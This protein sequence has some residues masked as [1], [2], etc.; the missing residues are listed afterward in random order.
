MYLDTRQD[1]GWRIQEEG[2]IGTSGALATTV[3]EEWLENLCR[4]RSI[5]VTKEPES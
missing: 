2:A 3:P 4:V 1:E 5:T